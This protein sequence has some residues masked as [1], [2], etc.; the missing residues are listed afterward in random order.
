MLT[1]SINPTINQ[2]INKTE[3][4]S[5]IKQNKNKK[6]SVQKILNMKV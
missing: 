4:Q 3:K 6:K 1:M 5:L 2:L